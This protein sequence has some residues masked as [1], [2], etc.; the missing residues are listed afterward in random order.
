MIEA[1]FVAEADVRETNAAVGIGTVVFGA[2]QGVWKDT[3]KFDATVEAALR[4]WLVDTGFWMGRRGRMGRIREWIGWS[5]GKPRRLGS[6]GGARARGERSGWAK[7]T[8]RIRIMI[9][10]GAGHAEDAVGAINDC[11]LLVV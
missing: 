5:I 4:Y 8:I 10:V 9:C 6:F 2:A 3:G 11:D 1:G 7:I